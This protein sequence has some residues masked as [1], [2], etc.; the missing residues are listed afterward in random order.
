MEYSH[1]W[2]H[3]ILD[4]FL[5]PEDLARVQQILPKHREGFLIEEDDEQKINYKFLP[6]LKL[7][8]YFISSDFKDFLQNLTGLNLR[9]NP[10]SLVQ[11]R[12]MTPDSP[13]FPPHVDSQDE[14][15]LVYILYISPNWNSQCGGEL[16]LHLHKDS[17]PYGAESKIVEPL[18]NRMILFRSEDYHWHSVSKVR[19]WLRYS[20]IMEWIIT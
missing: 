10:K 6:D 1:P 8:K 14:K 3:L 18:E 17:H 11:L 7:A 19:N 16:N 2:N 4:D 9:L 13:A 20:V 12:L 15:S 5:S